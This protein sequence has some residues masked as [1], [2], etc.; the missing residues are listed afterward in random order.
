MSKLLKTLG[1]EKIL[2]LYD[3]IKFNGGLKNSF[4]KL[5]R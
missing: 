1:L 3:I 4:L 5:Y 2:R